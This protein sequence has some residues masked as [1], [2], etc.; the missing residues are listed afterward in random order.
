MPSHPRRPVK[1]VIGENIR[2]ARLRQGLT[3][4]QLARRVGENTTDE[5]IS[6]WERGKHRPSDEHMRALARELDL[7]YVDF[8]VEHEGTLR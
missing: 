4:E 6:L 3:Q 1:S 8:F 7:N 2:R 5:R